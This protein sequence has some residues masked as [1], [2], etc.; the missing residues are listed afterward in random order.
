MK[1]RLFM[2]VLSVFCLLLMACGGAKQMAQSENQTEKQ[3]NE[4][5]C[6]DWFINVPE[7]PDHLYA[8][9]TA[10]SKD[11][12]LA[13]NKA[14]QDTRVKIGA[15]LETRLQSLTKQ[16]K[17]EIGEGADATVDAQ[18]TTVSK[19]VISTTLSGSKVKK[20]STKQE[21]QTWRAC[22]L[23]EYPI[24]AAN[25]RFLQSLKETENLRVKAAAT[26]AFKELEAEVEKY[27]Q[28]KEKTQNNQ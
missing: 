12:Q 26:E 27:E 21:G 16:F 17:E 5:P 6:P 20:Q 15:Q 2:M 23:M 13:I 1:S 7:D 18:F 3:D 25:A 14:E 19:T 22:V 9:A 4:S 11:L 8:A 24:G 28:E 10:T